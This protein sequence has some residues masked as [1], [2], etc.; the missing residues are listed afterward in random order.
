MIEWPVATCVDKELWSR[1]I[2]IVLNVKVNLEV[3]EKLRAVLDCIHPRSEH[4]IKLLVQPA[5]RG[6]VPA[7]L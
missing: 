6:V 1:A 7:E 5:Y 4:A 2:A 3:W